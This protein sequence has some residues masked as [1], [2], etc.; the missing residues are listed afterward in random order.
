MRAS[1]CL[2]AF[3]HASWMTSQP[4]TCVLAWCAAGEDAPFV[5][6]FT[7][8]PEVCAYKDIPKCLLRGEVD[9][10]K[11]QGRSWVVNVLATPQGRCNVS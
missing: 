3:M 9:R 8:Q 1:A 6:D 7:M 2:H 11:C 4:L 5:L 10:I